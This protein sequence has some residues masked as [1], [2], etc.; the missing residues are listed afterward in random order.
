[1]AR[2]PACRVGTS[3][4][5]RLVPLLAFVPPT[6]V[7]IVLVVSSS[8]WSTEQ[9]EASGRSP[10][11]I[12]SYCLPPAGIPP[13]GSLELVPEVGPRGSTFEVQLSTVPLDAALFQPVQAWWDFGQ[14]SE[15]FLGGAEGGIPKDANGVSFDV[16]VPASTSI[17]EHVVSVCWWNT[18]LGE[19]Y[20][21]DTEFTVMEPSPSPT[22]TGSPT[23][24][25]IQVIW[26]DNN[27]SGSA[28]PVDSLL[29]LRHDAGLTT[30]TGDCLEL[31]SSVGVS[32]ASAHLW[33]DVDCSG[34]IDPV[35]SLKLLRFDAGLSVAQEI[36]CPG[37][38]AAVMIIES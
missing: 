14:G 9:G 3:I 26:G 22:P 4:P 33:R 13:T 15:A 8:I 10:E 6:F 32:I 20:R 38:G 27:C 7:T 19:R 34:S 29:T 35:D 23:P 21:F 1:M 5:S 30:N 17:G 2:L 24:S 12:S 25:P 31:G 11:G 36:E 16:D 37:M 18:S 28:D